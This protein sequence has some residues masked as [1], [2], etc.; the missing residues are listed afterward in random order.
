MPEEG[1]IELPS[2]QEFEPEKLASTRLNPISAARNSSQTDS[3]YFD[4]Q[5]PV[6]AT[7]SGDT[8]KLPNN[9]KTKVKLKQTGEREVAPIA[10][11]D[12]SGGQDQEESGFGYLR[13]PYV[14]G[15]YDDIQ[16]PEE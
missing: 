2:H 5:F 7:D 3:V 11:Y 10:I 9:I 1:I 6:Y 13:G 8:T 14:L 16:I 15:N 12:V 4:V